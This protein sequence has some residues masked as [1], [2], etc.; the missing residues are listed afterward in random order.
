MPWPVLPTIALTNDSRSEYDEV[1]RMSQ[2][3][4]IAENFCYIGCHWLPICLGISHRTSFYI[5]LHCT[6]MKLKLYADFRH[7]LSRH[8]HVT[9]FLEGGGSALHF[10]FPAVLGGK[11]QLRSS[12]GTHLMSNLFI[13]K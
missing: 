11:W 8:S 10:F 13:T 6:A 12:P 1:R 9:T 3:S 7:T 5:T 4:S 2:Q